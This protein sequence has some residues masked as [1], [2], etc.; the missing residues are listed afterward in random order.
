MDFRLIYASSVDRVEHVL[1]ALKHEGTRLATLH[2]ALKLVPAEALVH[3]LTAQRQGAHT[4]M[5]PGHEA[6]E[7]QGLR[8]VA[9]RRVTLR[10][11]GADAKLSR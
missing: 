8:Q 10:C 1:L 6:P 7:L 11:V 2:E 4:S 3:A 5:K 9:C